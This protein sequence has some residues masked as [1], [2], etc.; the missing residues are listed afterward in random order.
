MA[1]NQFVL[2]RFDYEGTESYGGPKTFL[3]CELKPFFVTKYKY[4]KFIITI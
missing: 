4:T 1:R 3:D 2:V